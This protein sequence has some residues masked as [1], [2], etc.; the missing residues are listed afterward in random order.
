MEKTHKTMV[1]DKLKKSLIILIIA[2][3]IGFMFLAGYLMGLRHG[4]YLVIEQ[5]S[6][7][8]GKVEINKVDV[9]INESLITEKLDEA[10]KF[11]REN[12][13]GD[14]FYDLDNPNKTYFRAD[15]SSKIEEVK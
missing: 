14:Y 11:V 1:G 4:V 5:G 2:L 7:F 3:S 13:K 9:N 6:K 15:G 12:E 10:M 8:I